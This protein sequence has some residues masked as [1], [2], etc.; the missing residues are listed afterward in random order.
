MLW[1][2]IWMVF[3]FVIITII[4][5]VIDMRDEFWK[6]K[7]MVIGLVCSCASRGVILFGRK[8]LET[9]IMKMTL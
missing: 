7:K 3:M 4:I 2:R 8:N 6:E 5:V 9:L 1:G